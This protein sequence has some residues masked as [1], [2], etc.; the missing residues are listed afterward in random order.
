MRVPVADCHFWSHLLSPRLQLSSSTHEGAKNATVVLRPGLVRGGSLTAPAAVASVRRRE[1]PLSFT[2]PQALPFFS[3]PA[4]WVYVQGTQR[5]NRL[6]KSSSNAIAM[7]RI[8]KHSEVQ[9]HCKLGKER[10]TDCY[11]AQFV[12]QTGSGR[13]RLNERHMRNVRIAAKAPLRYCF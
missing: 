3:E 13:R 5:S 12:G 8:K 6:A 2:R 10:S 7:R 11:R 9:T 4:L 1:P